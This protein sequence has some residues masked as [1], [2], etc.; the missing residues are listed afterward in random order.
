MHLGVLGLVFVLGGAGSSNDGGVQNG[1]S[2]DL[3]PLGLQFLADLANSLSSSLLSLSNLRNFVMV[4]ESGTG[5]R[6]W[7]MPTKLRILAL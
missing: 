2:V 1:A 5:S 3:E 7:P 6:P 4:V